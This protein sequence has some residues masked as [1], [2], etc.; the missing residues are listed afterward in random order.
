MK[1]LLIIQKNSRFIRKRFKEE[2][3]SIHDLDV[4]HYSQLS[5]KLGGGFSIKVGKKE[6]SKKN[7]DAVILRLAGPGAGMVY[8]KDIISRHFAKT[9]YVLNGESY[10]LWP[11]LGKV[12]Q[13]Y[14]LSKNGLP[15][16]ETNLYATKEIFPSNKIKLPLIVKKNFGKLGNAVFKAESIKDFK[17]LTRGNISDYLFQ[18]FFTTGEDF[19]V[20][21]IGGKA[22][23][24]TMKKVAQ[25][26]QFI[27]NI[28][29]GGEAH[30][31][32]TTAELKELAEKAA[33]IFKA[34]YCGVDVMYDTK[35][36]PHVLE[37]N[38]SA[39][40]AGF[41]AAT[42]MNVVQQIFRFLE[43]KND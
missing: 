23:D 8:F 16:A 9:S 32:E 27:T 26:G 1:I 36:R 19:R 13:S 33:K 38:R 31:V 11:R 41:E 21:V 20:I 37:I 5:I 28:S 34:D 6:L 4:Y 14:M 39:G 15:V 42:G 7:Y 18:P 10:I 40:F 30:K 22:L 3:D 2:V 35:G 43:S 29:Q 24:Y 25:K 12:Q 17:T